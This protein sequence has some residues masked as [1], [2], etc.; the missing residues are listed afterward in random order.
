MDVAQINV[1]ELRGYEG[2]DR[3]IPSSELWRMVK[4]YKP[5]I[6]EKTGLSKLDA[7]ID[8]F[9][10]EEVI[11]VSGP[12]RMGK[13]TLCQTIM[14]NMTKSGKRPLF[15]S[16]EVSPRKIAYAHRNEA[17]A[18]YL[19][20]AHHAMNIEWLESRCWEAAL[21]YPD[22]GAIFIDHLHY[23]VDMRSRNNMSLEIGA[24]MRFLKQRIAI[25]L[26]LPVFLVAHMTKIPFDQEPGLE[27]LRDSALVA[28]EADT[29]LVLWRQFD[30]DFHGEKLK[31][32]NQGL[33]MLKIEKAR[34]TGA[35]EVRI[36]LCKH[37]NTL[38]EIKE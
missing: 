1:A 16:Y 28:C 3:V 25:A 29:V 17:D 5:A 19:P 34:R 27:H 11:V 36:P 4:D 12:T 31:T 21:K 8:G 24:T 37:E 7:A 14:A 18:I 10:S 2:D 23:V 20:L 30:R 13:T 32:M 38:V 22:L 33:A 9:E 35:M 26:N 6:K 15:F